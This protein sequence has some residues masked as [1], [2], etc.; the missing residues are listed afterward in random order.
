MLGLLTRSR[1]PARTAPRSFRPSLE[2]LETRDCPSAL[3]LN[4]TYG[5]GRQITLSGQVTSG[6]TGGGLTSAGN[7]F[8]GPVQNTGMSGVTVVFRGSA[9]GSAV[10]DPNGN[11]SLTTNASNL[12]EVNAVTS[13]GQSNTASVFLSQGGGPVISNFAAT[14]EGNSHYWDITGHV[15]DGNF[16]AQ[17]LTVLIGGAPVTINNSGQGRSAAVDAAGNFDLCICLNG[18]SSDNGNISAMVADAWGLQSNQPITT[19]MQPGT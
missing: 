18:T 7:N 2:R 1:R 11:F 5:A 15:T 12:G 16:S 6:Q 13:D 19:I 9:S 10:S 4:V 3:T 8:I 17:G 14:E